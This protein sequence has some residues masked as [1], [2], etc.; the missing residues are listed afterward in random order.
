MMN[1]ATLP[2]WRRIAYI[3]CGFD[4]DEKV[5]LYI[6]GLH[7]Y[8]SYNSKV[9]WSKCWLYYISILLQ[10]NDLNQSYG[11]K[12]GPKTDKEK[13]KEAVEALHE[14]DHWQR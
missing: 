9:I 1:K 7:E 8:E 6:I 12:V 2:T 10:N 14:P 4:G 5:I 11:Y 13:A 3:V